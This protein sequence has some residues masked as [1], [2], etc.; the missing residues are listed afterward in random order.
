MLLVAAQMYLIH[1]S[2]LK[3]K[4]FEPMNTAFILT[5]SNLG[6]RAGN[7]SHA[8]DAITKQCG[9]VSNQSHLYETAAWGNEDQPAFLNQALELHTELTARQLIRKLLKIEKTM[10]RT[11]EVRY[12]PRLIDIDI[13]LFNDEIHRYELLKLPHPEMH[14]RRFALVPLAEIAPVIIHP[15]LKMTIRELL[16]A[17]PDP[18]PVKKYE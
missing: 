15:E 2:M 5:G 9:E 8:R 10:G 12:G 11:R 7:L 17:C 4:I 16:E 3:I 13:L 1:H 18:L 14:R 6:D